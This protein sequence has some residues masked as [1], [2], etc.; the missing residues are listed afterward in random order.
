[1]RGAVALSLILACG[2]CVADEIPTVDEF[3]WGNWS[4]EGVMNDSPIK[5]RWSCRAAPGKHCVFITGAISPKEKRGETIQ[6]ASVSGFNPVE[7][8]IVST[9]YWSN[10]DCLTVHW[11]DAPEQWKEIAGTLIGC[12]GG[13]EIEGTTRI[14]RKDDNGFGYVVNSG[15]QEVAEIHFKRMEMPSKKPEAARTPPARR[16]ETPPPP[17]AATTPPLPDEDE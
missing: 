16:Y 12:V 4:F 2:V 9:E 15:D 7:Q 3:F 6:F 14:V 17:T 5:G 1:M 11:N 13:E 10:G 8:K